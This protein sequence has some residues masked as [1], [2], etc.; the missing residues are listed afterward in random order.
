MTVR[1]SPSSDLFSHPDTLLRDHLARVAAANRVACLETSTDFSAYGLSADAVTEVAEL[2]GWCHDFG[3]ASRYFQEYLFARDPAIRRRLK[4]LPETRHGLI[5][6]LFCYHCL[7][8]RTWTGHP[9]MNETLPY[10][11]FLAVLRHHGNLGDFATEL[12]SVHEESCVPVRRQIDA[13]DRSAVLEAYDGFVPRETVALFLDDLPAII[14]EFE[15]GRGRARRVLSKQA[16]VAYEIFCSFLYSVLISSDKEAASGLRVARPLD[17]PAPDAVDRYR[18]ACGFETPRDRIGEIRNEIYEAVIGRVPALDLDRRI[19]S[20]N[21]PTGTGKTLAGLSFALKLRERLRRERG[22]TP[23]IIYSLPFISIIDQNFAVFEKVLA[24]EGGAPATDVL[25]KHHGLA[26]VSFARSAPSEDEVEDPDPL[27]DLFLIE[28]W[29]A[30]VIVTT[31]VQLFHTLLSNRNRALRKYHRIA[32]AIVILDEIQSIPHQYWL[33]LNRLFLAFAECLHTT[34]VLMTA[35]QP[36][37]FEGRGE[38][39]ELVE[40]R[41]D[42]F[43]AFDRLDLRPVLAPMSVDRFVEKLQAEIGAQP[44]RDFLIVLNTIT[45]SQRVFRE[46]A[47]RARPGDRYVYLSTMVIPNERL[48]RIREVRE[49]HGPRTVIV[50]TQLIEAGVDI[51]VDV[52]YRDFA[53]LDSLNQVAGRCN[54]NF[55]GT[56]GKVTVVMLHDERGRNF[57]EYIY[58]DP[59]LTDLTRQLLEGREEI[60]ES[61][62]FALIDSYYWAVRERMSD[63]ASERLLGSCADLAYAEIGRFALIEEAPWKLD[64]FVAVDDRAQALWERFQ[65]MKAIPDRLERKRAFLPFRREFVEYVISVPARYRDLIGYTEA[66]GLGYLSLGEVAAGIGYDT[67]LGFV[68]EAAG[69]SAGTLTL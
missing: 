1:P 27:D 58:R 67:V 12:R 3:K 43:S 47:G 60:P 9:A 41:T 15:R 66:W 7:R 32:N 6:A 8:S 34:F 46:L 10:I 53:P 11:G 38:V 54:R 56:R 29:N 5:S 61:T 28:G 69:D 55:G 18:S 14:V 59:L 42:F 35:T 44:D 48:R 19:Y 37:I 4:A 13:I 65:A 39:C 52:V 57:Y 63:D 23:R 62:F 26:D 30:E 33:L 20:L 51:D 25:L 24:G 64:L 22:F 16:D 21:A 31:F 68:G 49:D 45:S 50:S 2:L 36:Y 40:G 17:A